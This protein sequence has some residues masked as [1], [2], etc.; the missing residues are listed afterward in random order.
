[1][2]RKE[3]KDEVICQ[4]PGTTRP[5]ELSADVMLVRQSLIITA[6]LDGNHTNQYFNSKTYRFFLDYN[7]IVQ[8]V[9]I[10]AKLEPEDSKL[11]GTSIL[12]IFL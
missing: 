3:R 7:A 12:F 9:S 11:W 6:E 5:G 4:T 10:L 2:P 8:L 1:M